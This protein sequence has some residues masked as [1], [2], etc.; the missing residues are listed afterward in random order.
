MK[1]QLIKLKFL[2]LISEIEE[3]NIKIEDLELVK[4]GFD[5]SELRKDIDLPIVVEVG[6]IL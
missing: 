3:Y 4:Y 1:D 6:K 5:S 2:R